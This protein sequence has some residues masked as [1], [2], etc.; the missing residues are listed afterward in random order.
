MKN[1]IILL[2]SLALL[3]FILITLGIFEYG[4]LINH[5]T[6]T[7]AAQNR[8]A[9]VA[10]SPTFR[11][12]II[13]DKDNASS[14]VQLRGIEKAIEELNQK[15]GILGKPVQLLTKHACT[16]SEH[17]TAAQE[18]CVQSDVALCLGPFSSDFIPS[19]RCLTGFQAL[20]LISSSTVFSDKLPP[21]EH[22]NFI[23]FFPPLEQWTTAMV[24]DIIASGHKDIMIISPDENSYGDIFATDAERVSRIKS[25]FDNIYRINYQ[26]PFSRDIF[27]RIMR[28]H[29]DKR[30]CDVVI[31]TGDFLD[32]LSF[33]QLAKELGV[34]Q[35]VYGTDDLNVTELAENLHLLSSEL[36]LPYAVYGEDKR[37][38]MPQ[39]GYV[40][41]MGIAKVIEAKGSF[42]PLSLIDDLYAYRASAQYDVD[43]PVEISIEVVD[44]DSAS[45]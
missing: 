44:E 8:A 29:S 36:R 21:L 15:G 3:Y 9:A 45:R 2:L 41:V 38:N 32:F 34:K 27:S 26:K 7:I 13:I 18:L 4:S 28:H 25:S 1:T 40:T 10:Q 43:N 19:M 22:E 12:G 31:F 16:L 20:P 42:D 30:L 5:D 14:I 37:H 33:T 6:R 17:N 11:M 35:G 23:S 39:L 24:E